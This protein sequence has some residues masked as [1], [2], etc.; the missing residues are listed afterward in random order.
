MNL[1]NTSGTAGVLRERRTR[2]AERRNDPPSSSSAPGDSGNGRPVYR[3]GGKVIRDQVSTKE[4]T[5]VGPGPKAEPERS[6]TPPAVTHSRTIR[7]PDEER[8]AEGDARE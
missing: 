2:G 3:I 7:F 1:D 5:D 8:I 6:T 4:P